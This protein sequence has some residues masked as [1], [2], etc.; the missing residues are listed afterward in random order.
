M[1]S[2]KKLFLNCKE[3]HRYFVVIGA[4][5]LLLSKNSTQKEFLASIC[6]ETHRYKHLNDFLL[7]KNS[8]QKDYKSSTS[9]YGSFLILR[10][11]TFQNLKISKA[12]IINQ[13]DICE[14]AC[15]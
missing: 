2:Q 3:T 5:D 14:K 7:S 10:V 4:D 1:G 11:H 15:L 8:T 9:S 12:R 6:K 13:T